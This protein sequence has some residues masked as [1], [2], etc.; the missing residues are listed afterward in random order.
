MELMDHL[1]GAKHSADAFACV[2]SAHAQSFGKFFKA[3]FKREKLKK[4]IRKKVKVNY[5]LNGKKPMPYREAEVLTR[6]PEEMQK[7]PFK[8]FVCFISGKMDDRLH[9]MDM[10]IKNIM[11]D[12]DGFDPAVLKAMI[13][14]NLKAMVKR[15]AKEK[16]EEKKK[17][18]LGKTLSDK[19]SP[20]TPVQV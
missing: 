9:K 17:K 12:D 10:V 19:V 2:K 15:K 18:T 20:D 13:I 6:Q 3:T 7:F 16:L 1:A 11:L 8:L 14:A 4:K 5:L